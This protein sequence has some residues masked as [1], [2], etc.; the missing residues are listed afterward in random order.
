MIKG[1]IRVY[2]IQYK[3]LDGFNALIAFN[4][5]DNVDTRLLDARDRASCN[6]SLVIIKTPKAFS[7]RQNQGI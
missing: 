7:K 6:P 2:V 4:I 3:L 1:V 5:F